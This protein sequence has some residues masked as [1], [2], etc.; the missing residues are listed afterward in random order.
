MFR[1]LSIAVAAIAFFAVSNTG[2][3]AELYGT[4]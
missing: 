3:A 4:L 2:N 1:K